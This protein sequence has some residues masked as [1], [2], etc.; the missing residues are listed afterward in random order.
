MFEALFHFFSQ[1]LQKKLVLKGNLRESRSFACRDKTALCA[2]DIMSA[3]RRKT[4]RV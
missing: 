2:I 1:I 4:N 3:R